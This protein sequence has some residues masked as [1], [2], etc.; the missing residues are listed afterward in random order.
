MPNCRVNPT[1]A[2]ASSAAVTRPN[3]IAGSSVLNLR[4]PLPRWSE[5]R[6]AAPRSPDRHSASR[7]SSPYDAALSWS[8]V[9]MVS[10]SDA[11][12]LVANLT[13]A[14][15]PLELWY[16]SKEIGPRAPAYL[17]SVPAFSAAAPSAKLLTSLAPLVTA[18]MNELYTDGAAL[19]ALIIAS[20]S[21]L[22]ES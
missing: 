14:N 19:L 11:D 2:M 6:D 5:D 9:T 20:T 12:P 1:A 13:T 15:S 16:L 4:G 21:R 10:G 8:A 3:P 17:M 18:G 22:T 7:P